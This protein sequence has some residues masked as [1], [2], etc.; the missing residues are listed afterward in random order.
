MDGGIIPNFVGGLGNQI[1]ILAAAY[2]VHREKNYQLYILNNPIFNN[3]HNKYKNN[4]NETLFKYFGTHLNENI[5]DLQFIYSNGYREIVPQ[6]IDFGFWNPKLV[7]PNSLLSGYYQ[8][9]P[10]LKKYETEIQNLLLKGLEPITNKINI[11][12][13]SAFLHVRRG[14]AHDNLH[15]YYLLPIE[16]YIKCVSKLLN[17][18][19]INKIYIISDE[20]SW[21]KE[22]EFFKKPIF[23]FYEN[24]NELETFALM[25]KCTEGAICGGSTFSWWGAF[26]GAYRNKNPVFV[27]KDW[28]K[29]PIINLFPEE[30][31]I[32]TSSFDF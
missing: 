24:D 29:M 32:E 9:Y 13:N 6:K 30:W 1:F 31:N 17:K 23:E 2:V 27:P 4:Y 11:H 18:K 22:Q 10:P 16:Y 20:F 7:P 5:K 8:Y 21:V 25:T 15:I 3:K 19:F 28:I 14:D 26:L 12:E